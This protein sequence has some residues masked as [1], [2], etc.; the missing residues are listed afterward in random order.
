MAQQGIEMILMRRLASQLTMP[1]VLVDPRGDLVYFNEAAA[2]V[3]GRRFEDTGAIVRGEWSTVF[4]PANADGSLI[5][6]EELPLFVATEQRRPSH[7]AGW[8]RGL[9]GVAR[10]F[11]GIA[12][13]LVGQGA[14]M[15][16]AVGIFWDPGAPPAPGT[17]LA[18]GPIDLASPGGDRPVELLLM[19]Q[20]AS[21]LSTAIFLMGPDGTLLFFNEPSEVLLGRR[22]EETEPM[23]AEQWS[24]LLPAQEDDGAEIAVAERPIVVALRNQ[25][26]AHKRFTIRS[27]DGVRHEIEGLGV[28]L[29]DRARRQL[30]AVGIFWKRAES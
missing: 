23:N 1:I 8:V 24:K 17:A 16:G 4:R 30:G 18:G 11:E 13:P 14:R 28:P 20:L 10:S 15:L 9:D 27:F 5:K 2:D 26:P 19:R 22:F 25:R 3:L 6:R 7:R 12:F 21:Y 29:V